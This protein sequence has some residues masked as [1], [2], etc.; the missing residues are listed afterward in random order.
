[1]AA[2]DQRFDRWSQLGQSAAVSAL[3]SPAASESEVDHDDPN[4]WGQLMSQSSNGRSSTYERVNRDGSIT[5]THAYW[6]T[7]TAADCPSCDHRS[8][9]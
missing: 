6:T 5:L 2:Q 1:M 4:T 7:E 8:N 3:T 9:R